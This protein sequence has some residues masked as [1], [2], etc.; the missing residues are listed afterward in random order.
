MIEKMN[1]NP[2]EDEADYEEEGPEEHENKDEIEEEWELLKKM[3]TILHRTMSGS[4]QGEG[5]GWLIPPPPIFSPN[6]CGY[7]Y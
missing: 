1:R 5:T 2:S 3:E 6:F 4:E 7:S